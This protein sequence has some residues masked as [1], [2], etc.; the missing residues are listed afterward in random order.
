MAQ[1]AT[2]WFKLSHTNQP[3]PTPHYPLPAF[4]HIF[5]I[6]QWV[7]LHY[8]SHFGRSKVYV[9]KNLKNVKLFSFSS[10]FLWQPL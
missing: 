1:G 7:E 6:T 4:Q 5:F 10:N 3:P 9:K 2:Y 8:T